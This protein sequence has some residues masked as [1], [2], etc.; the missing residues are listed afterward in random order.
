M[1]KNQGIN[2]LGRVVDQHKQAPISG[3]KILLNFPGTP[4]VVYSDL[5]GIYRFTAKFN[6]SSSLNGQIT[7]EAKGYRTYESFIELLPDKKDLGDIRLVSRNVESGTI[8]S[9][10]SSMLIL[11]AVAIL[12]ALSLLV[13]V[14]TKPSNQYSVPE[15][16]PQKV[17]KKPQKNRKK[18]NYVSNAYKYNLGYQITID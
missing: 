17:Y 7:I 5:E 3:A 11:I 13:L 10:D 4:S 16:T 14:A 2:F 1:P 9:N 6:G 15:E 8:T 12:T 18:H